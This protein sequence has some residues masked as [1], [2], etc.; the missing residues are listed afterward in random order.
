MENKSAITIDNVSVLENKDRFSQTVGNN[1]AEAD[2]GGIA[3][4]GTLTFNDFAGYAL[5]FA[6]TEMKTLAYG[7][8]TQLNFA[9]SPAGTSVSS[10]A[11]KEVPE[12]WT[13]D[14]SHA[15]DATP[16]IVVSAPSQDAIKAGSAVGTGEIVLEATLP[17]GY[18]ATNV[19]KPSVR[20]YGI[21]DK[22]EFKSFISAYGASA[23]SP[24][25]TGLDN[26]LVD[27]AITLNT[28]LTVETGD[29]ATFYVVKFL[30]LPL[31]GNNRTITYNVTSAQALVAFCQGLHADVSNLYFDGSITATGKSAE[32][33]MLAA[34]GINTN[35]SSRKATEVTITNVH[36][37]S[38]AIISFEYDGT[39]S[40][41]Y[42]AGFVSKGTEA[43]STLT[44]RNCS[45]AGTIQSIKGA[46][47][48]LA[49]FSGADGTGVG[50][51]SKFYDCSFTGAIRLEQGLN[52]A[53]SIRIG[54]L[55]A[56]NCRNSYYENCTSSG[57]IT[58]D[59]NGYVF[60]TSSSKGSGIG[61]LVGY[62]QNTS[63][64]SSSE[65]KNCSF[66]GSISA[67]NMLA[68]TAEYGWTDAGNYDSSIT[69]GKI[70][71]NA[72]RKA[73]SG[74]DTCTES[75]SITYSFAE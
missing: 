16:Y 69:F 28:D 53:G 72:S 49:G 4:N 74:L 29:L 73:P 42:V 61:G 59:M 41:A 38:T 68:S 75:G 44:Y 54:G 3:A 60:N 27:G 31:E 51:W 10:I 47:Q 13:I 21:N 56:D 14:L 36:I 23:N 11:V 64:G 34:R 45:V 65:F 1:A 66:S 63:E 70:V 67:V 58:A 2:L 71:G 24:N 39:G 9:V 19:D 33:C 20:L 26:W 40:G 30:D 5:A 25:I 22:A 48:G 35:G 15:K 46:P 7:A 8:S 50:I 62:T 18:V 32:V 12:G 55:V 17:G 6:E 43:G 52:K 37:K 57:T